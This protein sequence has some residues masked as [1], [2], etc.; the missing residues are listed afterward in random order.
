ME[1]LDVKL[2]GG[3]T[4]VHALVLA[5]SMFVVAIVAALIGAPSKPPLADHR[6]DR[7]CPSCSWSGNVSKHVPRCPKCGAKLPVS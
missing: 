1:F 4:V 7:Y 5:G 3:F 6:T 2:V